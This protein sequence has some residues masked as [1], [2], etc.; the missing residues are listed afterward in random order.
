MD[1][2]DRAG[3]AD[4]WCVILAAKVDTVLWKSGEIFD[5]KD[6]GGRGG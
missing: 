4:H 5:V 2:E 1:L 3:H 6:S